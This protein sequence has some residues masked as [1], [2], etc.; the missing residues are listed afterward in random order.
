M[1]FAKTKGLYLCEGLTWSRTAIGAAM[2]P[3]G[4]TA[5]RG[6][7][8][9]ASAARPCVCKARPFVARAYATLK[10]LVYSSHIIVTNS[11]MYMYTWIRSFKTSSS[12]Q[13][14]N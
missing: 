2:W 8:T 12:S 14:N 3:S 4:L 1:Q 9:L 5:K 6:S 13:H 11:Q 10:K 7:A